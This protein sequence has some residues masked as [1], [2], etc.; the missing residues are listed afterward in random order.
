M[1]IFACPFTERETHV[2]FNPNFLQQGH[3]STR[4]TINKF[5]FWGEILAVQGI[6]AKLRFSPQLPPNPKQTSLHPGTH[7]RKRLYL[8]AF[9]HHHQSTIITLILGTFIA[10]PE[11]KKKTHN[12]H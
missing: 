10:F 4:N 8:F 6:C 2:P 1:A 5:F 3:E 11:H 12:Q 9:H 7:I